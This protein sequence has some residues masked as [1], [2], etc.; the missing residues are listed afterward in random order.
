[1]SVF[2]KAMK[3]Q[4]EI[5]AALEE[6]KRDPIGI[7]AAMSTCGSSFVEMSARI[8]VARGAKTVAEV[9]RLIRDDFET[10]MAGAEGPIA[11]TIGIVQEMYS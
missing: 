9:I 1:V 5:L 11:E 7:V 10:V 8:H 3:V 6:H 2:D 4:S